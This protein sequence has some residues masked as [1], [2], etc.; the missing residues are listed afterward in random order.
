MLKVSMAACVAALAFS[1]PAFAQSES[2]SF[3]LVND[4]DYTLVYLYISVPSTDSWEEDILGDQVVGPG[5]TVDVTIDDGLDGCEY[6]LRADFEDGESL[7]LGSY[8]FCEIDG[9]EIVVSE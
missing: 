2:I 1:A 4:T 9:G 3:D 8:D 5:E 6:D 7:I